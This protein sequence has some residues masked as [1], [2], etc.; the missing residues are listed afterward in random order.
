MGIKTFDLFGYVELI[1]IG[2]ILVIL[3]C[4]TFHTLVYPEPEECMEIEGIVTNREVIT[5]GGLF[6]GASYNIVVNGTDGEYYLICS[7][8]YFFKYII[9]ITQITMMTII[10]AIRINNSDV[11]SE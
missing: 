5:S 11:E 2:S 4:G 6:G 10:A 9:R 3:V 7:R 1:M 8:D